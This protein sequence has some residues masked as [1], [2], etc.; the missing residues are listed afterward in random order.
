MKTLQ[1]P[2][3]NDTFRNSLEAINFT[4]IHTRTDGHVSSGYCN[5]Y[6]NFETEALTFEHLLSCIRW[7][8][9]RLGYGTG[10]PEGGQESLGFIGEVP[11]P[12]YSLSGLIEYKDGKGALFEVKVIDSAKGQFLTSVT[13]VDSYEELKGS[14]VRRA[15]NAED[16]AKVRETLGLN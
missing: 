8:E 2:N 5:I 12:L 13:F 16:K 14:V 10:E 7:D 3:V 9:H 1:V 15:V 11:A 6:S 4:Y